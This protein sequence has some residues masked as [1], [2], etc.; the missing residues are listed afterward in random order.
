M[1]K[2]MTMAVDRI[3]NPLKTSEGDTSSTTHPAVR[4]ASALVC[5]SCGSK[6]PLDA[7]WSTP[8]Q[9]PFRCHRCIR[10]QYLQGLRENPVRDWG[11]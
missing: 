5:V 7:V 2:L 3:I 10:R 11:T 4:S 8:L 6:S 9:G 1:Y